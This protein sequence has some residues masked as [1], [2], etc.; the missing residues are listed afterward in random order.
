LTLDEPALT[1]RI[2]SMA[3]TRQWLAP[4]AAS[5][6]IDCRPGVRLNATAG[7]R[8][9]HPTARIC[10]LGVWWFWQRRHHQLGSCPVRIQRRLPS[11]CRAAD[12]TARVKRPGPTLR[13]ITQ[14]QQQ[15]ST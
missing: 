12:E 6:G 1:T 14:Y 15:R 9:L 13:R 8:Y 3:I 7:K 10:G 2:V 4:V 5:V 11:P